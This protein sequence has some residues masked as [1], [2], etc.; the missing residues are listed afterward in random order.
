VNFLDVLE[1]SKDLFEIP[2]FFQIGFELTRLIFKNRVK[3][4]IRR[5]FGGLAKEVLV[6]VRTGK[7]DCAGDNTGNLW[8]S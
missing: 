5:G 2:L 1:T 8:M 6:I 7:S 3:I 4:E